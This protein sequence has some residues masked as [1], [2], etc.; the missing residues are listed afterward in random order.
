MQTQLKR[1]KGHVVKLSFADKCQRLY[2]YVYALCIK[3]T[4]GKQEMY[5]ALAY[6]DAALMSMKWRHSK[7]GVGLASHVLF[8]DTSHEN[9][10][11]TRKFGN[12]YSWS[13][14]ELFIRQ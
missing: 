9:N 13:L 5:K 3:Q 11:T 2:Q 8:S 14:N 12:V 10:K 4:T 1:D 6:I 7:S